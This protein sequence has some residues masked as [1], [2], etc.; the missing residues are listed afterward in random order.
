V[1]S[2]IALNY[3]ELAA[4]RLHGPA[5]GRPRC[6]R[7]A[8]AQYHQFHAL[9]VGTTGGKLARHQAAPPLERFAEGGLA[10]DPLGFGVDIRETYFHVLGPERHGPPAHHVQ[11]ALAGSR[12]VAEF[13]VVIGEYQ[14]VVRRGFSGF[15]IAG[16]PWIGSISPVAEPKR[17]L[18]CMT[19]H[20]LPGGRYPLPGPD[21]HRLDH[22]ASWRTSVLI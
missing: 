3:W 10:L 17:S 4:A 15:P 6:R 2:Y 13:G 11:A 22:P 7:R 1:A 20:S 18:P 16:M 5:H 19:Q 14:A 12:V 8:A 9:W 21:L